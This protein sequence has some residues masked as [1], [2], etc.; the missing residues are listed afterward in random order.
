MKP[1]WATS[2][3]E[4]PEGVIGSHHRRRQAWTL[5]QGTHHPEKSRSSSSSRYASLAESSALTWAI[6]QSSL[7]N[8]GIGLTGHGW[9][10][11]QDCP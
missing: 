10:G 1:G 9:V 6:D 3:R 4:L 7:A 8:P 2:D 5:A 11:P